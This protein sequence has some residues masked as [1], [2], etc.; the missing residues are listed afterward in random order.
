MRDIQHTHR[1]RQRHKTDRRESG[2]KQRSWLINPKPAPKSGDESRSVW[3]YTSYLR[4][5]PSSTSSY[6]FLAS[7]RGIAFSSTRGCERMQPSETLLVR[8]SS[9]RCL[10]FCFF[11]MPWSR[12][13][14]SPSSFRKADRLVWHRRCW[15]RACLMLACAWATVTHVD[16]H[17]TFWLFLCMGSIRPG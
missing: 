8:K 7:W 16:D 12:G 14:C 3:R 10:T 4:I 6:C 9:F 2:P 1:Q 13:V 17:V 11:L 15:T 5:T